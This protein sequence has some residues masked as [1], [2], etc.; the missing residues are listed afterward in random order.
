M[1]SLIVRDSAQPSLQRSDTTPYFKGSTSC[2]KRYL[3]EKGRNCLYLLRRDE[4]AAWDEYYRLLADPS[5]RRLLA[6]QDAHTTLTCGWKKRE[7]SSRLDNLGICF[8]KSRQ[9]KLYRIRTSHWYL[10]VLQILRRSHTC[11]TDS[12]FMP[13]QHTPPLP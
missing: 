11:Y 4:K 2:D 1:L 12:R 3:S 10:R 5:S 6:Q 7:D 8:G 13:I 9:L